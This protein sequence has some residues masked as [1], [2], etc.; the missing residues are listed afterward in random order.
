MRIWDRGEYELLKADEDRMVLKFL[1]SK[2]RGRY[3][4]MKFK[5]GWLLFK[6]R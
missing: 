2:L 1:G 6:T 4:L 3:V 5:N